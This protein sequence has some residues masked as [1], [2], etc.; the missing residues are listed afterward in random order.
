MGVYLVRC[1]IIII[2]LAASTLCFDSGI[3]FTSITSISLMI[4]AK[5][6]NRKFT[7]SI[8]LYFRSLLDETQDSYRKITIKRYVD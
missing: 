4:N 1:T 5:F 8:P 3:F 7:H 2:K 6:I